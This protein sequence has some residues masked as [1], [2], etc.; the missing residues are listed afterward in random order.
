MY[1]WRLNYQDKSAVCAFLDGCGTHPDLDRSSL[2]NLVW[3]RRVRVMCTRTAAGQYVS[4]RIV[5]IES[6]APQL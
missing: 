5:E 1:A 6:T 4:Q 3:V 2:D